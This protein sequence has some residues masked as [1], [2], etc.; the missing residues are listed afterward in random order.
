MAIEKGYVTMDQIKECLRV[1]MELEDTGLNL[2]LGEILI[3]KGFMSKEQVDEILQ[4]QTKKAPAQEIGGFQLVSKLGEGAMGAVYKAKQ[5]NL[6]RMVALKVLPKKLARNR[7]F[8][9]R[10]QRE[11]KLVALLDHP[12]SVRGIDVGEARGINY[13][14]ME[15]V[16]G[17]SVG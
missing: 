3:R 15:F 10:F 9:A 16:E 7:E 17:E 8:V 14:A 12:N 1:K 2:K 13:L 4:G 6:D 5:V 11:A